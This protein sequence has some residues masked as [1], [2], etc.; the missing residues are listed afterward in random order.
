M[1]FFDKCGTKEDMHI[2]KHALD[3]FLIYFPINIEFSLS[4]G[5][6]ILNVSYVCFF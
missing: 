4:F 1:C 2:S 6:H 3:N 5:Y